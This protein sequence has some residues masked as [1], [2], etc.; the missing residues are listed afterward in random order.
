MFD[1]RRLRVL[2]A[3]HHHGTVTGAAEALHLSP[4]AVSQQIRQ[5]AKELGVALL[6]PEGRRVRLTSAAV[7]L[8]EHADA[9]ST[10]WEQALADL[11][12]HADG[13]TGPLRM[14]GFATGIT[15]LLAPA[16]A[17]LRRA[18]PQL[19]VSVTQAETGACFDQLLA[20]SADLAVFVPDPTVVAA[21][22]SRFDQRVLIEEPHDLLVPAGH[23]LA[24]RRSVAL[25]EAARED[26]VIPD[27]TCGHHRLIQVAC[28]SAGFTA[29]IAHEATEWSAATALVAHG[30]GVTL[31][32]RMLPVATARPV[33]RVPLHGASTP[34]RSILTC[35]RAGSAGHPAI[36][37][38]IAALREVAAE[39]VAPPRGAVEPAVA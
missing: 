19:S 5:L 14:S 36:A 11:A 24:A 32:P 18:H 13:D 9:L 34:S 28:A 33:V 7:V 39:A 4:S 6:E 30:L 2:R 38:G 17:R 21:E 16:A 15:V 25:A 29:R 23:P 20:G 37:R 1:L 8:L 31:V 27:G 10:R 22:D 26:W 12:V 35:V 3:V